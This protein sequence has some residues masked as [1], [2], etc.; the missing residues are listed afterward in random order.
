MDMAG[1]L[2]AF[3]LLLGIIDPLT[4]LAAFMSLTKSMGEGEKRKVALKGVLVAGIVFFIFA[5]GGNSIL[6]L[7][8]VSIESFKAAGGIILVLLGVQM[9]LGISFPKEKEEI[10]EIAVVI[11]TPLIT[12]PATITTAIILANE[13]GLMTTAIAGGAALLVTFLVLIFSGVLNRILGRAG[14]QIMATMMGIVTIA[15]GLQFLLSGINAFKP[16]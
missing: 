1:L 6:S 14:V 10:S 11:A 2:E 9:S 16:A 3:I 8:G 13:A 12:G 4:S 15:W 7:L 5:L